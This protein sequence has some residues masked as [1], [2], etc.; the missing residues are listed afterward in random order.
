MTL[1][2]T[3]TVSVYFFRSVLE[4]EELYPSAGLEVMEDQDSC[5]GAC[6][7]PTHIHQRYNNW[8]LDCRLPLLGVLAAWR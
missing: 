8:R 4:L 3:N 5:G 6:V 1:G 7:E 2:A